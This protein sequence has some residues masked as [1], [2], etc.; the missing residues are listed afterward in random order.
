MPPLLTMPP[1]RIECLGTCSNWLWKIPTG[2]QLNKRER[3]E[4]TLEMAKKE[5]LKINVKVT[6]R[7][8]W[9]ITTLTT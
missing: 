5:K 1:H 2:M 9:K 3:S 6:G 4:R 7:K 8:V